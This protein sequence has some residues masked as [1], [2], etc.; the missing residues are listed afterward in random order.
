[1]KPGLDLH[2][3]GKIF[4]KNKNY[5]KFMDLSQT[6][7]DFSV[8]F[9]CI[10]VMLMKRKSGLSARIASEFANCNIEIEK[11]LEFGMHLQCQLQIV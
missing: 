11:W 8:F 9:I 4:F 1:M 6:F 10:F 2:M 5:P 7:I 3:M